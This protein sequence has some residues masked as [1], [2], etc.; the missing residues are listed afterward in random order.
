VGDRDLRRDVGKLLWVGFEGT[1]VPSDLRRRIAA[2]EVGGV[3]LFARN[4]PRDDDGRADLR[5]LA[6]LTRD[7]R[8]AAEGER[9]FIA[10]DQEGGR[11]QRVREPLTRWPPMLVF[12]QVPDGPAEALAEAVGHALGREI[13]ALGFDVDFAPVLDVHTNPSNPVIGDRAFATDP[14]RVAT[15]ALAFARGLGRAGILP[16]GK[17]FPG[18]GD[19]SADSHLEL[20]RLDHDLDRLRAVE[21]VPFARAAAAGLP[22]LMT[23]HVVFPALDPGVPATLS[24]RVLHGLLREEL[25][26]RGAIVSDDLD[27]NAITD[28][29]NIEDAA[30]AAIEAGCNILLLCRDPANQQAAFEALGSLP[31]P[32]LREI[33]ALLDRTAQVRDSWT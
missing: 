10:V 29:I 9:L 31:T 13:A 1:S 18:H 19:T 5:G 17:H 15:R 23:A 6:A 20:P 4:V 25:G 33:A 12:D 11:V 3:V 14:E 32:L 22:L 16:C 7:L 24:R 26:Y 27:M 28:H 8:A 30:V 21:L 2:G